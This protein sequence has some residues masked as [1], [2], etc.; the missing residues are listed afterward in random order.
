MPGWLTKAQQA[1]GYGAPEKITE[2]PFEVVCSCG[3]VLR[4]VRRQDSRTVDCPRCGE[5]VFVL[6]IDVY[7][8]PRPK[9]FP[10]KETIPERSTSPET[11]P[12]KRVKRPRVR[13]RLRKRAKDVR[14]KVGL[15][16]RRTA[17]RQKKIFTPFRLVLLCMTALIVGTIYLVVHRSALERAES[18]LRNASENG[19]SAL[20]DGDFLTASKEFQSA[21]EALDILGRDDETA[22]AI[23]Q[24]SKETTAAVHLARDSLFEIVTSFPEAFGEEAASWNYGGA[25]IVIETIVEK[26][27]IV[28]GVDRVTIDY[29]LIVDDCSV[30]IEADSAILDQLSLRD[31]PRKVIFAAQLESFRLVGGSWVIRLKAETA[32]LWSNY[33]NYRALSFA[34]EDPQTEQEL[35]ELLDHQSRLIGIKP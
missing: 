34:M 14:E 31:G 33:D 10:K 25:W 32:F 3:G 5:R 26:P 20:S 18:T 23:R 29:P 24:M 35:R 30:V 7:P 1:F 4:G 2:Q 9:E 22:R 12:K 21:C 27:T 6:S 11:A 17:D 19:Y 8:Q 15:L 16:L 13:E 28:D